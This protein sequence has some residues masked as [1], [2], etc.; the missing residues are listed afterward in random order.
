LYIYIL[1]DHSYNSGEIQT[2]TKGYRKMSKRIQPKMS[3]FAEASFY[4]GLFSLTEEFIAVANLS[5][6]A[7]IIGVVTSIAAVVFGIL[8]L[9]QVKLQKTEGKWLAITGI[10]FGG[11]GI[12]ILP[13][14]YFYWIPEV[15]RILAERASELQ[16]Q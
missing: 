6:V 13:F 15:Q 8:G 3:G 7:V 5:L 16:P 12:A 10:V 4:V 11:I 2:V 1:V 9:C 14:Y